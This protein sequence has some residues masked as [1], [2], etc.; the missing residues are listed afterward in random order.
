MSN[1]YPGGIIT[2][3]ANAGYSVAFDGNGDSLTAPQSN[4]FRFS[5]NFTIE[6]WVYANSSAGGS[7]YDGVFDT[8][9]G[10]VVSSA[11]AGIN[12]TPSGYLNAYVA[13]SN[14]TSSTLLGANR[15]VHVALVRSGSAV[16]LYQNGISVATGTTSANL[17][18]GYC[19]VG[20]FV[21]N[22]YWN[23]YISNVRVVN[24]TAVYSGSSTTTANFA[25]PTQLFPITNTSFLTCQ[26]PSIVDNSVNAATITANGNAAVSTFTP[27]TGT[28]LVPNPNTLANTQGVWSISDAAYWMSQN[29]W[30][31][32]PSYPLQSLRFNSADSAYLTRTPTSTGN[33]QTFT[34]SGW[35][36]IGKNPYSTGGYLFSSRQSGTDNFGINI[37]TSM[38]LVVD[39][40]IGGTAI[41][42]ITTPVYRDSSAWYH[43]LLA[44]DTTQATSTNRVK[45]YVNGTQVTAFGTA[46][47]P[48]QSNTS[49]N[50]NT[51]IHNVSGYNN[52]SNYFDG[53]M[54]DVNFVDG[55]A[56]TPS[57]FGANDPNTGVWSPVPYS[58][59]YGT[60]GFRLSFQDNTGTTATTL[61]KDWSG[62]GNNWT[63]NNFSVAAGSGND[64]LTDGPTNWGIDYGNGGEV[65]GN[66]ATFNPLQSGSQATLSNGN[67][68]LSFSS[69]SGHAAGSTIAVSSGKWYCEFTKGTSGVIVGLIPSTFAGKLDNWPGNSAYGTDSYGYFSDTGN[70]YNNSTAT[71]Y[72]ATWAAGDV[73]GVALD[74]TAGT[75]VF[76]KNGVSQG[77]AFSGLTGSYIFAIGY[78]GGSSGG[79][80]ISF[81]A[82]QRP[83]AYTAPSG[84]KALCTQNLPTPAVGASSST[85]ANKQ[86]DATLY[87]GTGSALTVTNAGAFKPDLVWYK[88][89]SA[90]SSNAL[91]DAIR[92][93][94]KWLTS[95]GTDAETTISG[96]SAFN[97]NGFS[98][99]TNAGGNFSGRSYVAWQWKGGN[100]TVSNTAGS[101]T[102]T[103]SANTTAGVSV[104]TYTGN[105]S[106]GATVGHG[107]GVAPRLVFVK[108]R[109]NAYNWCVY[110][111]AANGGNGQNGGFYLN[112]TDAWASD[113][114]FWNNTAA[115]SSVL[116][117]GSGFAVNNSG[118]TYVAYCFAEIAGF[119]KFGSYTGNGSADGVFVYLGFRP[120]FIMGR[121]ATGVDNW[122][123]YDSARN[124]YNVANSFLRPNLSD[125]E[126]SN[127]TDVI[128]FLSNGFKIRGASNF[129]NESGNTFIY[130]AFAEAPFNYSRAR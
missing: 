32:P 92:G 85:L 118:S 41:N 25:L 104:V 37:N 66:Y 81:N 84:F 126:G 124:T 38:Q 56:L 5:G 67:L 7:N 127:T 96:V 57:S 110:A 119:S 102:S 3:G 34:W 64:S 89:R 87:T 70:K 11:S 73:I 40:A 8:R 55:Q 79:T 69:T 80:V 72:G 130:A 125:A 6:A 16:T 83:F 123:I 45:L 107:L 4:S 50:L 97:S 24:G 62:Q 12:Y 109:S 14:L 65:R 82:G 86:F 52:S 43:I 74:L 20:G 94:D 129:L 36:K 28:Q 88:D 108:S 93:V 9:S 42:L 60:N 33:R 121:D 15:W 120:R 116:T 128:D 95:N 122:W 78:G 21:A 106:A 61:G 98:L 17:T 46:T 77:T 63:P 29:K 90:A 91:F 31:M 68:D 75:L 39:G 100:G 2:S 115:T 27:F 47:Y 111:R 49:V 26:S 103:V 101:I 30:P 44:V 112:L 71:S 10:N 18:D 117:L 54:A 76:Y 35:V 23:G 99:G 105:G 22:G 1:K 48:T 53:Y 113:V 19:T 51:A 59:T 114:G 13:G 58:G